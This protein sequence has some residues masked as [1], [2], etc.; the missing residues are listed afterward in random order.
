RVA[1]AADGSTE[2]FFPAF[3]NPAVALGMLGF[4][5]LWIGLT[6]ILFK[7]HAPLIFRIAWPFSDLLIGIWVLSLLFGSTSAHA[8]NGE[9]TIVSRLLG[10]PIR[11]RHTSLSQI[12]DIRS[13]SGMY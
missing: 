7:D 1:R 3:R 2:I 13:G 10:I 9:I 11:K 5:V 8:R 6:I 4:L 12:N